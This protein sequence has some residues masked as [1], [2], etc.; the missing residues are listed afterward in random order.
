MKRYM[1]LS[2]F[3]LI[4]GC[5]VLADRQEPR[6]LG[7]QRSE[8]GY[9]DLI[10]AADGIHHPWG[11][12]FL[13]DGSVLIT[14]RRGRLLLYKNGSLSEVAG[15][16]D[17]PASGQGGL[18][19][20]VLHPDFSRNRLV[21]F[22]H[23]A[24]IGSGTGTAVSRAIFNGT[25]VTDVERVF[26]SN[27][28]SGSGQ[29]F[30]SRL[31]F[32]GDGYLYISLGDR[33]QGTRAQDT[34]DHAGSVLRLNDDGSIPADNPLVSGG[35]PSAI[36][37]FGHRNQQG[38]A[39]DPLTGN[40]WIHEH[41]PKGGDEMNI[42]KPGANYGWPLVTFG[43]NYN[44]TEI[45]DKTEAPG[46]EPPLRY[47]VPSIAPSGMT[48]YTGD[49][50]PQWKNDI[51]VGALAGRH[52]RRLEREGTRILGEEMLLHNTVGRIRDVRT[53]PDGHV[54]FITDERNGGLFYLMP[55]GQTT[56]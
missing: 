52:L 5:Q 7:V 38:M 24:R 26:T 12:A 3:L 6:S 43:V 36:F 53:G 11:F 15:L 42:L 14:E 55:A 40:V 30:G 32:D 50:F 21:Y 56:E 1:L 35:R 41:G 22:S 34:E 45:S 39:I 8:N 44:G 20:I 13:E 48:F 33:G 10:Q 17:I 46:L 37:T 29:H 25:K 23:S 27:K 9:F 51:F 28:G 31:I 18:L 2:G 49:R 54:W 19:D 4:L 47:W 16:P